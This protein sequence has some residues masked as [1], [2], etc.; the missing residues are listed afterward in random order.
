MDTTTADTNGDTWEPGAGWILAWADE[1]NGSEID[2]GKWYHINMKWPHNWE[3]EFY[4]PRPQNSWVTNGHLVIKAIKESYSGAGYTSA[5]LETKGKYSFKYGKIAARI[6]LPYGTNQW[7][8]FWLLGTND[9]VV[10][11]PNC[12]EIDIM[13]FRGDIINKS[14]SAVHGPN[15]SAGESYGGSYTLPSGN[16]TNSFHVFESVWTN[17]SIKF[18]VNGNHVY[19]LLKS[20]VTAA[21]KTWVFDWP[22]Y[23]IMNLAIGSSD[24][25][26]TGKQPVQTDVFPTY[27]F[28]DWVRVY[29]Y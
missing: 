24:T 25:P 6:R 27:M 12:G 2:T 8:A 17:D 19:T 29:T 3:L 15:Y 7:P 9:S 4:T 21:S 18:Y 10:G 13:E 26:Y 20:T 23:I 22:F 1:F 5:R 16:F 14:S 11:W 28:V